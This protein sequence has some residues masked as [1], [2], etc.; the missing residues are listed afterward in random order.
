MAVI[1]VRTW[2]GLASIGDDSSVRLAERLDADNT[3]RWH[4]WAPALT[5][6]GRQRELELVVTHSHHDQALPLLRH[7][8]VSR[9]KDFPAN[10]ISK[11]RRLVQ[12]LEALKVV[13]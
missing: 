9:V 6:M 10:P 2:I 1:G 5:A 7:T 8:V 13:E 4:P 3:A 11:S 12:R